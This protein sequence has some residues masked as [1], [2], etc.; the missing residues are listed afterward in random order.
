MQ[1]RFLD[2]SG[3]ANLDINVSLVICLGC[4]AGT[5]ISFCEVWTDIVYCFVAIDRLNWKCRC[6][7]CLL[8]TLIFWS[9][10]GVSWRSETLGGKA[11]HNAVVTVINSNMKAL[12]NGN[13]LLMAPETTYK[14]S[15]HQMLMFVH[16]TAVR[17]AGTK[18]FVSVKTVWTLSCSE[19]SSNCL[20]T[21]ELIVG[22]SW[23]N[24]LLWVLHLRS[25]DDDSL[26]VWFQ[27]KLADIYLFILF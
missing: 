13:P 2:I 27:F 21:A 16:V 20:L 10:S 25:T 11:E 22:C 6:S 24:L 3:F 23:R 19:F 9:I 18:W 17:C 8:H 15:C 12:R 5:R 7:C 4:L 26:P 1:Q 14:S